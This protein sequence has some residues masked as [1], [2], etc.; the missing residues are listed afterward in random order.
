MQSIPS[1]KINHKKHQKRTTN[2]HGDG[3]LKA[4]L[5]VTGIG[6]FPHKLRPQSSQKLSNK[7]VDAD[8]SGMSALRRQVTQNR[9]DRAVVP[10]HKETAD[11]EGREK[12]PLFVGLNSQEHKGGSEQEGSRDNDNPAI[13]VFFLDA[14]SKVAA[15]QNS[16]HERKKG[17][18]GERNGRLP[19]AEFFVVHGKI[20]APGEERHTRES[21]QGSRDDHGEIGGYAQ[22]TGQRNNFRA[23]SAR[24]F[25]QLEDEEARQEANHAN[26]NKSIFPTVPR[27]DE[28]AKSQS[29]GSAEEH[30]GSENRLR[31]G[32]KLI[33]EGVGNH[34]LSRRCVSRFANANRSSRDEQEHERRRKAACDSGQTPECDARGDDLGSAEPVSKQSTRDTGDGQN[35]EE[36]GL[37]GTELC[38]AQAHLLSEKRKEGH[39]DLAVGEVDKID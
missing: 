1:D 3:N 38:V 31:H 15:R 24:G 35:D 10:G 22:E 34:G 20:C 23:R 13:G 2:H 7:H 5:K 39:N 6:Y 37:Q 9:R 27:S 33:R 21:D 29:G 25:G 12:Q 28:A 26:N 11:K 19:K 16:K 32:A 36:P 18:K 30:A 14:V 8:G 17:D 4:K